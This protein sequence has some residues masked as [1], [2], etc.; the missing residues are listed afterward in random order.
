MEAFIPVRSL[1]QLKG[2]G[3]SVDGNRWV[4]SVSGGGLCLVELYSNGLGVGCERK[5]ERCQAS[6]QNVGSGN[7][8]TGVSVD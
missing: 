6:F 8:K 5:E 3:S 7:E 1:V 2:E 4:E